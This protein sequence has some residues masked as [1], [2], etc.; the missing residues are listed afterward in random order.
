LAGLL[1]FGIYVTIEL[2]P[3][4]FMIPR[5]RLLLLILACLGLYLGSLFMGITL[6]KNKK[7]TLVRTTNWLFFAFYV[8]LLSTLVLFDQMFGRQMNSIFSLSGR[9][10][11]LYLTHAVNIVPFKEIWRYV[12]GFINHS[13]NLNI[14][15]TNLLG[16]LVAFTPFALFLPML[17]RINTFKRFFI[18]ILL[19]TVSV[20]ILQ[21][22][23]MSGSCDIDDVIL[24]VGG[25]LI[26]YMILQIPCIKKFTK[27]MFL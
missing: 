16:N 2:T 12:A 24:N 1:L 18:A 26:M 9:E 11:Q 27:M 13:I 15:V 21:L 4:A 6:E 23:T 17:T 10:L 3:N 25:A 22:V 14:I 19:I 8:I 7:D 5:V 20:E